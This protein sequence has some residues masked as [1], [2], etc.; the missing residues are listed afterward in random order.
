MPQTRGGKGAPDSP[1]GTP[2]FELPEL[3]IGIAGASPGRVD[4][5]SVQILRLLQGLEAKLDLS[6]TRSESRFTAIESRFSAL[7]EA[8]AD[9]IT[10]VAELHTVPGAGV[11]PATA[12]A[13]GPGGGPPPGPEPAPAPAP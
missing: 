3:G 7:E 1:A 12:V 11:T 6:E 2:A 13:A 4:P 10:S 8:G 5:A 9:V